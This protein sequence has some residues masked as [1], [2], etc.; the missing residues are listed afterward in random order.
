MLLEK[1]NILLLLVVVVMVLLRVVMQE[2]GDEAGT[3]L[4]AVDQ[5]LVFVFCSLLR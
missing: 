5:A 2:V 3:M 1:S 4:W